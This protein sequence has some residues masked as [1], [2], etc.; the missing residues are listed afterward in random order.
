MEYSVVGSQ[1]NFPVSMLS[2]VHMCNVKPFICLPAGLLTGLTGN[3]ETILSFSSGSYPIEKFEC[4]CFHTSVF[5]WSTVPGLLPVNHSRCKVQ[6]RTWWWLTVHCRSLLFA[7][8][9]MTTPRR[10]LRPR[11]WRW[12]FQTTGYT[13][14]KRCWSWLCTTRPVWIATWLRVAP[15]RWDSLH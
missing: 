11:D 1:V 9:T 5:R 4:D 15:S 14:V 7:P 10:A 12:R 3:G 13:R 6:W 2:A 8:V